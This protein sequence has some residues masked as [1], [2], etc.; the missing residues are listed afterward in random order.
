MPSVSEA[1]CPMLVPFGTHP[2]L[3]TLAAPFASEGGESL[4]SLCGETALAECRCACAP[5]RGTRPLPSA[6]AGVQFRK[7]DEKL[8]TMASKVPLELQR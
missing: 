1:F 7:G 6:K 2:P 4:R 3:A 5:E 8:R